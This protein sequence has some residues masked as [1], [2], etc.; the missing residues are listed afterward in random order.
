MYEQSN[1]ASQYHG[2]SNPPRGPAAPPH[3]PFSQ[4]PP[5]HL[6]QFPPGVPVPPPSEIQHGAP[7][8]PPIQQAPPPPFPYQ[9]GLPAPPAQQPFHLPTQGPMSMGQPYSFT[10]P[11][12]S[13]PPSMSGNNNANHVTQGLQPMPPPPR[14]FPSQSLPPPPRQSLYRIP[15]PP[16][17]APPSFASITPA[18]FM[19]LGNTSVRDTH[20][21]SIPPPP[22]PPPLPPSSPPPL[23]PSPPPPASPAPNISVV[24]SKTPS[25]DNR[26]GIDI[27]VASIDPLQPTNS[28]PPGGTSHVEVDDT[29]AKVSVGV[30]EACEGLPSPPPKPVEEEVV[31]NIEV[32]C[33]FI[34]KVGPDFENFA[35]TKEVGNPQ[36]SFLFG[37]KPGSAAAIAREYF[38]WVKRKYCLEPNLSQDPK[39][40]AL[41]EPPITES[42][43]K[44]LKFEKKE[45]GTSPTVS[46]MDMEDDN[47]SSFM[48]DVSPERSP[49][50]TAELDLDG[51]VQHSVRQLHD[52]SSIVNVSPVAGSGKVTESPKMFVKD[53]SPFR[54][55]QGYASDDSGEDKREYASNIRNVTAS[56][57]AVES[58]L[59]SHRDKEPEYCLN[60]G[61][62]AVTSTDTGTELQGCSGKS[63]IKPSE[64]S[65]CG[66]SSPRKSTSPIVGSTRD[67]LHNVNFPG[68]DEQDN[69]GLHDRVGSKILLDSDTVEGGRMDVNS[70]VKRLQPEEAQGPAI[71]ILDEFGRLVREGF[72]DSE[73]DEMQYSKR[74]VKKGKTRSGSRSPQESRWRQKSRSPRKRYKR[75]RSSSSSPRRSKSPPTFRRTNAY[76]KRER[77]PPSDC[78]NFIRGRCFRGAS[79]RFLHRD[80]GQRRDRKQHYRDFHQNSVDYDMHGA[81]QARETRDEVSPK[82]S[83]DILRNQRFTAGFEKDDASSTQNISREGS[84]KDQISK[85]IVSQ[86][87]KMQ[88]VEKLKDSPSISCKKEERTLLL[89]DSS[90]PLPSDN[91]PVQSIPARKL[92]TLFNGNDLGE[93]SQG[94]QHSQAASTSISGLPNVQ[95]L[96]PAAQPSSDQAP[97]PQANQGESPF[98]RSGPMA[99]PSD[100]PIHSTEVPVSGSLV[101]VVSSQPSHQV[102]HGHLPLLPSDNVSAAPFAAEHL[103]ENFIPPSTS[104]HPHPSPSVMLQPQHPSIGSDYHSQNVHPLSQNLPNFPSPPQ[105]PPPPSLLTGLSGRPSPSFHVEYPRSQFEPLP[106]GNFAQNMTRPYHPA[107]L[108]L[109]HQYPSQMDDVNRTLTVGSQQNPPFS[110]EEWFLR[111]PVPEGPRIM[112]DTLLSGSHIHHQSSLREN[113]RISLPVDG[114]SSFSHGNILQPSLPFPGAPVQN[115][116]QSLLGDCLPSRFLQRE[117][118]SSVRGLPYSQQQ[119]SYG[120]QRPPSSTSTSGHG[121][122]DPSFQGFPAG[123]GE[124]N[125]PHHVSD[126]GVPKSSITTRYNPFASTFEQTPSSL[127][128]TSSIPGQGNVLEYNMKYD[129]SLSS[130]HGLVGGPGSRVAAI[131]PDLG[132]SLGHLLPAVQQQFSVEPASGL[133]YD[134]LFDSIEPST[135]LIKKLDVCQEQNLRNSDAGNMSKLSSLPRPVDIENSSKEKGGMLAE[136]EA[137]ELGEGATDVEVG[138]VENASPQPDANDW[139]PDIPGDVGNLAAGN[140][141]ID[142]VRS[143]GKSKKSKDSRSAKIFKNAIASFVKEVL[144]PSWRQGNMSKEAFKTIVK[145]TVDKVYDSAHHIPKSQAKITQYVESAERKITKLVM[146]YVDK[147]VKM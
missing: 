4:G 96:V 90:Q 86:T 84:S 25:A 103:R 34:A 66:N 67:A 132:Q 61:A 89:L 54:L 68:A 140:I 9:R 111:H 113:A 127:K 122:S 59:D 69:E 72:S 29:K 115:G 136:S 60:F 2:Q 128:I 109:S 30:R 38:Q 73:S 79:C 6:A 99:Q 119:T 131:S 5:G 118:F 75:S 44:A 71:P 50:A 41:P 101:P 144:K 133:P 14:V 39:D 8:H 26:V 46:D 91:L 32:L 13:Y 121:I 31:R 19:P 123:F 15:H 64:A 37:G 108:S 114:P 47:N 138:V 105:Q 74:H 58:I 139:S 104:Y 17:P 62:K 145:K 1:Y 80:A 110:R 93:L 76:A 124:S 82:K 40:S 125:L 16:P 142:Q 120:L 27:V 7:P 85:E 92:E 57:F 146:G 141:E 78:F 23:P 112:S 94:V 56:T 36:F 12:P 77:E 48:E 65:H 126:I 10:Q 3:P 43:P 87:E 100:Q 55:I 28:M 49:P 97:R 83:K 116:S 24:T 88:Q 35:R 95:N 42:S 129:L 117:E 20:P 134:P 18:P 51:S 22:P 106:S 11:G 21:P 137:D 107:E 98:A 143:S 147:Y 52:V 81:T 70:Q 130:G 45:D 135:S 102:L 33:Q 53:R 63:S